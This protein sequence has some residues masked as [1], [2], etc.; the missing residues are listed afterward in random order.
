MNLPMRVCGKDV[1]IEGKWV[2]VARLEAEGY[3]FLDTPEEALRVVR[4]AG[5]RIDIFT[6]I[7]RLP[8]TSRQYAYPMEWDNVA[9]VPVSTFEHWWTQQIDN[10]TRNMVRRAEKRGVVIR[11]VPFDDD[12][13]KGIWEIYNECPIRQGKPFPHFG[14]SMEAVRRAS[15]TFLDRAIFLGAFLGDSL[16]G[17]VKL[18]R[19]ERQTQAG[20]MQI[21]S[22]VQ[23]RDKAPTN[24][25][26]AQAVRSC[27][28]RGIP[29][30]WYA[31]FAYGNKQR[32]TLSDFKHHNGFQR[33]DL[34][35]Y[36]VPLTQWG[37]LALRLGLHR[38]LADR[39]PESVLGKFRELR[40]AWYSRKRQLK[41]G[42]P[43]ENEE[44]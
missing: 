25:L 36:Y 24:A 40:K 4:D 15:A 2:R 14:E 10:K 5:R 37:A 7:P 8:H 9:A 17:F 13:V 28:D 6:F 11:E 33:I 21:I 18:V 29:Y 19:D 43:R 35:R 30:L 27:A 41:S 42:N 34:P 44:S 23:H 39:L 20:T 3:D 1:H 22:M 38:R 32:D 12:L 31:N 26:I 16:I